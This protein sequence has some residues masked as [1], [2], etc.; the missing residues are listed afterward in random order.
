MLNKLLKLAA[1]S[2]AALASS[3]S[4]AV[5]SCEGL[6]TFLGIEKSGNVIV[7]LGGSTSF[8]TICNQVNQGSFGIVPQSC[9]SAYGALL[10]GKTLGK[11][12]RIYYDDNG[13]TCNT[14]PSW[15]TVNT[16]YLVEGPL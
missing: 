16:V 4:F 2:Y 8:H 5:Y 13:Y 12:M 9:K 6:V 1:I 11:S 3:P 7:A 10:A 15:S 14:I